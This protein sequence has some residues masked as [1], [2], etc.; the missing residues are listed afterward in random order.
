MP[1]IYKIIHGD[2]DTILTAEIVEKKSR[3]IASLKKVESE[4][5][6]VKFI[7]DTK[8]KY[9]D[10]R[11]NCSAFIVGADKELVRSNDDGEPSGTAGKPMLEVLLGS[12]IVNIAVVVTRYF[13]GTLLGTGGLVRAYTGAV[14]EVLKDVKIATMCLGCRLRIQTDY[15]TIG[16]IL[17]ELSERNIPVETSEY[18]DIIVL[19]IVV[20]AE[21]VDDIKDMI[22]QVSSGKDRA[23]ELEKLYFPSID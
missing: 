13:G 17:Y 12:E 10:A 11:H 2:K 5:E 23:T 19:T 20:K 4:E 6:A 14:Q 15:S 1:E 3:F 21:V 22:V 9:Y 18:T 16:K 8:K 7:S